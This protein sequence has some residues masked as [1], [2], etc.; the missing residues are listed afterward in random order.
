MIRKIKFLFFF[1]RLVLGWQQLRVPPGPSPAELEVCGAHAV[2]IKL[3]ENKTTVS[4][5]KETP[6]ITKYKGS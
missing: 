3:K 1:R 6:F 5:Q 4:A 2:T